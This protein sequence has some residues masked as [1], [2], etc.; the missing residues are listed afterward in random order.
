[1]SKKQK[2]TQQ[3]KRLG[4]RIIDWIQTAAGIITAIGV[5]VAAVM[6]AGGYLVKSLFSD[7]NDKLDKL[8]SQVDALRTES[9]RTQLIT[10]MSNYPDNQ[11]EILKLADKYFNEMNGDFYVTSLFEQ[12]ADQHGV[13]AKTLLSH[14]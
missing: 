5:I 6:S 8:S 9:V 10:L 2:P 1:M 4:R 3:R 12:W 11:A 14:K 13:D 7:T